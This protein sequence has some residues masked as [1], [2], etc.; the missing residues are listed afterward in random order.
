[1]GLSCAEITFRTAQAEEAIKCIITVLPEMLVGAGTVLTIEQVDI[2][3]R[4]SRGYEEPL[5]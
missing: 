1:M 5:S 4:C 2:R 3:R